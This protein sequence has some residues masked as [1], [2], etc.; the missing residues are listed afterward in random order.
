MNYTALTIIIWSYNPRHW[1][2]RAHQR[3]RGAQGTGG[4]QRQHCQPCGHGIDRA[5]A[6]QWQ[7]G[8]DV[9]GRFAL[10]GGPDGRP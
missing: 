7:P 8:S 2:Q 4:D 9:G 1:R 10:R 6:C 3:N 5:H